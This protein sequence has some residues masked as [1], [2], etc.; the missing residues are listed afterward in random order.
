MARDF[1]IDSV[2]FIENH[3][4]DIIIVVL[5]LFSV[6]VYNVMNNVTFHKS[7]PTLQK[8]VVLENL[9][10]MDNKE[11]Q[12]SNAI[13]QIETNKEK[14]AKIKLESDDSKNVCSGT[15]LEKNKSC[16]S[17]LDKKTCGSINCCVW[18]KKNSANKFAC[19]GGDKSG[20]TYDAHNYDEYYYENK[21]Y[22]NKTTN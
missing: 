19:L 8:I 14:A 4:L 18:A 20:P 12:A 5:L 9:E 11:N 17:L 21:K 22:S 13:S 3:I 2:T 10:N 1:F 16:G 6:L 7:H 15:L